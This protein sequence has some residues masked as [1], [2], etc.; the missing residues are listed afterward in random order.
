MVT[1]EATISK[2][3]LNTLFTKVGNKRKPALCKTSK[4]AKS[5]KSKLCLMTVAKVQIYNEEPRV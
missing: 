1:A 2:F 5:L 4:S 3:R